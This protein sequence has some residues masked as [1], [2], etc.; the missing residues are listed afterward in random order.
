MRT[1]VQSL[2][3][4][5]S[6]FTDPALLF[7]GGRQLDLARSGIEILV[8]VVDALKERNLWNPDKFSVFIDGGVR[9]AGDV[10]KAVALGVS[11]LS[12]F[13][14]FHTPLD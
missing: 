11:G 7:S 4:A 14:L 12:G 5:S 6:A 10:L 8:E 2:H 9:R 13:K 3:P 1:A